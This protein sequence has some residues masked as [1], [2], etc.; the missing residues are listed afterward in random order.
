MSAG[1]VCLACRQSF[2]FIEKNPD[3]VIEKCN[4]RNLCAY[5][6]VFVR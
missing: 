3:N 6:I 2:S 5:N 4:L 1:Q